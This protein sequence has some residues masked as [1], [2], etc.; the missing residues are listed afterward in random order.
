MGFIPNSKEN[1]A[2]EKKNA[3]APIVIVI[4]DQEYSLDFEE[5]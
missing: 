4:F 2:H 1:E 3:F 5:Q